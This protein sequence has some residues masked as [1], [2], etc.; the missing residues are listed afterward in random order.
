MWDEYIPGQTPSISPSKSTDCPGCTFGYQ[1]M[2]LLNTTTYRLHFEPDPARASYA[3]LS[4]VWHAG[5]EQ[6]Y[7]ASSVLLISPEY[8]LTSLRR[9]FLLSMQQPERPSVTMSP[10]TILN[11]SRL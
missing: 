4:H 11:S 2:W 1:E 3:I 6:S 9:I 5:T 7:Q 10:T 8:E